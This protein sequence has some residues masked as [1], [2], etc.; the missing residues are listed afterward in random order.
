[1]FDFVILFK[2]IDEF[3]T[4]AGAALKALEGLSLFDNLAHLFFDAGKIFLANRS[5]RFDVVV[6]TGFSCRAKR[7]LSVWKQAHDSPSHD[8]GTRMPK[9]F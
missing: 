9:H 8:V 3:A 6:E 4:F 1:M 5:R 7:K 2:I